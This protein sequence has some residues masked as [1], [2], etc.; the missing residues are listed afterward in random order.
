MRKRRRNGTSDAGAVTGGRQMRTS[1]GARPPT[2]W[3]APLVAMPAPPVTGRTTGVGDG[4]SLARTPAAGDHPRNPSMH[5][6]HL[7][8]ILALGLAVGTACAR[9]IRAAAAA[10]ADAPGRHA[11]RP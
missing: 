4:A 8:A 3:R 7:D 11:A 1:G 2:R 10:R 5:G 6:R 9:P